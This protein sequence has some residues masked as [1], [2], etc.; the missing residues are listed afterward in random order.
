[1]SSRPRRSVVPTS[2]QLV[3]PKLPGD[4]DEE[5]QGQ[6]EDGGELHSVFKKKK[7]YL[8]MV[9]VVRVWMLLVPEEQ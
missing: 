9:V 1:M 8:V 6:A 7:R 2:Y 4:S 3:L 5:S